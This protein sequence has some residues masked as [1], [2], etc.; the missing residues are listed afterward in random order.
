MPPVAEQ[1]KSGLAQGTFV[2]QNDGAVECVDT[3]ELRPVERGWGWKNAVDFH[4]NLNLSLSSIN[5][6]DDPSFL[7]LTFEGKARECLEVALSPIPKFTIGSTTV[8]RLGG[9]GNT[10]R[11]TVKFGRRRSTPKERE[12][13]PNLFKRVTGRVCRIDRWV[14]YWSCYDQQQ[15]RVSVGIGDRP[16]EE[17][18]TSL[19]LPAMQQDKNKSNNKATSAKEG[20]EELAAEGNA[21]TMEQEEKKE[22]F[23]TEEA[24][25]QRHVSYRAVGFR[26]VSVVGDDRLRRL[27][28]VQT[29]VD[30][31]P[32]AQTCHSSSV[33]RQGPNDSA[34]RRNTNCDV[35]TYSDERLDQGKPKKDARQRERA[36]WHS[37]RPNADD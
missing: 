11:T 29:V 2:V 8:I 25:P 34:N 31:S 20:E 24:A 26:N 37:N 28:F 27:G 21:D 4:P 6:D 13:A 35:R 17:C 30:S 36:V 18:I 5:D 14:K 7:Y 33:T 9:Y 1:I 32:G 10:A 16:G 15:G 3:I 22:T 23:A 12:K 19:Q